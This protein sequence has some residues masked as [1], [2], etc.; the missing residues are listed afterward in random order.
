MTRINLFSTTT[1][2]TAPATDS[3]A[4]GKT[5]GNRPHPKPN[6]FESTTGTLVFAA[7][8]IVCS[9]AVGC[10]SDKPKPVT[11][12]APSPVVQPIAA[13]TA[14][15]PAMP[16]LVAAA[17]PPRKKV[18][19]K[20]PV[21]VTYVD[22][23]FG[24][25]FEYPRNYALKTGDAATELVSSGPTAMD[26]V[27]PGGVALA[28]VALPE[29]TYPNSDLA[30]AFF[31]VSLNKTLTA[32]QCSEFSVPQPN[33]ALPADS[34]VKATAQLAASPVS[35]LPVSKLMIG[36]LELK[37]AETSAAGKTATGT[38]EQVSKYYHVFENGSCYEFA[39]EVATTRLDPAP[40]TATTKS[41]DRD[42]VFHRLEKILATV[43]LNPVPAEIHA[44]VK[45][46]VQPAP[47]ATPA[48]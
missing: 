44:E 35:G 22:K 20:A 21:T 46:E 47:A 13:P 28:A 6:S 38:R 30:S 17:K 18:V 14:A 41:V 7:I 4:W 40:A 12:T 31:N 25:S 16:A 5:K 29:S 24:V 34:A 42:Q 27:Q 26:F 15:A 1:A 11:S 23:T 43:K 33:P 2:R 3:V 32:D 39:L 10:S 9:V 36:D 45:T 37:S 48:Q 19:R 8:L